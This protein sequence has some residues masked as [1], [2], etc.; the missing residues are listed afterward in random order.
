MRRPLPF[1]LVSV[2]PDDQQS[3]SEEDGSLQTGQAVGAVHFV[4]ILRDLRNNALGA[5]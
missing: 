2:S 4:P 3:M 1:K 5:E